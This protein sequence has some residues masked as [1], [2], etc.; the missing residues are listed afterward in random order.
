[1]QAMRRMALRHT[2]F[3]DAAVNTIRLKLLNIGALVRTRVRRIHQ[4]MASRSLHPMEFEMARIYLRRA[5][6][7]RRPSSTPHQ[8]PKTLILGARPHGHRG[9]PEA[10]K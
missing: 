9:P 6:S 8:I 7:A 5:F 10:E 2:I 1:M 3:V 4:A